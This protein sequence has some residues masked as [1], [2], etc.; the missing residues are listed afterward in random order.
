MYALRVAMLTVLVLS[1][2]CHGIAWWVLLGYMA[3]VTVL[4]SLGQTE[5]LFSP[6]PT[7][8]EGCA[9]FKVPAEAMGMAALHAVMVLGQ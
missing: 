2:V 7:A 1:P 6:Q 8:Q 4:Q 9:F 5:G 3:Q